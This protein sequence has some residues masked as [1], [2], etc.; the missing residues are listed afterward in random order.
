MRILDKR[1]SNGRQYNRPTANEVTALLVEQGTNYGSHRDIVLHTSGGQLQ[2]IS[3]T[4]PSCMA[5]QYPL[6]FPYGEDGW[7]INIPHN[8]HSS[9]THARQTYM[10]IREYYC[11]RLHQLNIESQTILLGG[12]LLHQ[13]IVYAYACIVYNHLSWLHRN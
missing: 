2:R 9:T 5:L 6:L 7:R 13:F 8:M 11:F 10:S 4:Q 12:W 1:V 3:E